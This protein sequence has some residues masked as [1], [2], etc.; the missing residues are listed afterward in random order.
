MHKRNQSSL[1][2]YGRM[3]HEVIRLE[4]WRHLATFD[5]FSVKIILTIAR[6]S[7]KLTQRVNE[8]CSAFAL[9]IL[10]F[11]ES[12]NGVQEDARILLV[13]SHLSQNPSNRARTFPTAMHN[14]LIHFSSKARP[15]M[16]SRLGWR[17]ARSLEVPSFQI[18]FDL[19]EGRVFSRHGGC[20]LAHRGRLLRFVWVPVVF[21]FPRIDLRVKVNKWVGRKQEEKYCVFPK[22]I[23]KSKDAVENESNCTWL[24]LF[25]L[26]WKSAKTLKCRQ[27]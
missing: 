11:R 6:N 27:K 8:Q 9:K 3:I 14:F 4:V 1:S 5:V 20:A 12:C 13:I 16:F 17:H 18:L 24:Y 25:R 21:V 7:R 19:E 15:E 10:D 23:I 2:F 22:T 26:S